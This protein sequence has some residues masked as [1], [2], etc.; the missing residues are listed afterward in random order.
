MSKV[1]RAIDVKS[2]IIGVLSAIAVL[3]G[4]LAIAEE[5]LYS[6]TIFEWAVL[7]ANAERALDVHEDPLWEGVRIKA[8]VGWELVNIG[9]EPYQ[10]LEAEIWSPVTGLDHDSREFQSLQYTAKRI[11]SDYL[12]RVL[13]DVNYRTDFKGVPQNL[14]E[15][16]KKY[17][18]LW[19][20]DTPAKVRR[21]GLEALG[22]PYEIRW[23]SVGYPYKKRAAPL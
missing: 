17:S 18:E 12:S 9:D 1:M 23:A 5:A 4:G 21:E 3:I 14:S 2:F 11:L 13:H 10:L 15:W 6:P 8:R 20:I 7:Q 19:S 16:H 22:F